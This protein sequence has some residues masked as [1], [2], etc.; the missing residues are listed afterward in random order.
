VRMFLESLF[1]IL[2][3]LV[4]SV[5][6]YRSAI[7]EY[8]IV[9]RNWATDEAKWPALLAEKA[10]LIV[11]EV[12]QPWVRLWTNK[13]TAKFGWPVV[14]QEPKERSR[15]S[16]STWLQA[17]SAGVLGKRIVNEPDLAIAAGLPEQAAEIALNFRS[18]YW[19]P[20][21]LAVKN[22]S[23]GVIAPIEGAFVGLRK[24]TAEATCWIATDGKPLLIWLAHEGATKGGAYLPP[25]P[26][27][28]NPWRLK[29]EE[30]PW[31]SELKFLEIRLRPGNL[32]ILPPHWWVAM[33]CDSQDT[34]V[35]G[36][37]WYWTAE[38]HSPIS[39]LATRFTQKR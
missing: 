31:I 23:A 5:I 21:S 35:G 20:G 2:L 10:P 19:L 22:V 36:G 30:T 37:A 6:F 9:Q 1:V 14:I 16:W 3:L 18:P 7:H 17:K 26:Y 33:K 28:R 11:R 12:P 38:F 8:T 32:F 24:T 34:H 15:T 39:W 13:R 27:G 29:P 25:K 4:F